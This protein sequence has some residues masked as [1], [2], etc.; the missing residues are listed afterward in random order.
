MQLNADLDHRT[1]VHG[2]LLPWV[3]SPAAG[4]ERRLLYRVGGEKARA[5]S[6]V[7][8]AAGSAFPVHSHPGGEEFFVLEG[9]FQD[10]RGDYPAGTYV[11]N[12]PGSRHAPRSDQGCMIFVRLQQFDP[13][14]TQECVVAPV[15][16]EN[17]PSAQMLFCSP[18]EQVSLEH[19]EAGALLPCANS[20]AMEILV[21]AGAIVED[22]ELLEPMSW[23]R[24]PKGMPLQAKTGPAGA[25]L[26]IKR[27]LVG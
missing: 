21:L 1:L 11:R 8:Y 10:E 15:H 25:R 20:Y 16:G 2:A 5:T 3:P 26:W 19:W 14:D 4:I 12:P 23:L 22:T 17:A 24:L 27:S 18:T 13:Q 7:R 6:L 9:T